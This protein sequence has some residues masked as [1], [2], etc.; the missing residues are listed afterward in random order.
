MFKIIHID[1]DAFFASVEERDD[2]SLKGKPVVVGG[3]PDSRGV[4]ATCNYVARGFGIHSAMPSSQA[5]RLCPKAVFLKPRFDVYRAVSQQIMSI[6]QRFSDC[7]E[8]L[9]LDEAYLD[10]TGSPLCSG[11]ATLIAR[12]IKKA[13]WEEV[14]LTATAG[15]SYNKFF[16]KTASGMNKPDGL[17]VIRPEDGAAFAKTL[18]IGKF[19]G[20]GRATEEKMKRLGI[21]TGADLLGW[22]EAALTLQ[23]GKAGHFYAQLARGEDPRSVKPHR[24]RKSIGMEQTFQH[25]LRD[26]AEMRAILQ[27]QLRQVS[28]KLQRRNLRALTLVLKVKY[29]DFEQV[30]RSHTFPEPPDEKTLLTSLDALL[31]KTEVNSRAVRLLGVSASGLI[32]FSATTSQPPLC[33]L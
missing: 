27:A 4:V 21:R 30:T 8:P 3:A 14:H 26:V 9:S 19:F 5:F 13:I 20:I 23:F 24:E 17:T 7:V 15:V 31:A 25:D 2:P 1:M 32:T 16:A 22:S 28:E 18:P 10:V 6:F 33:L 29:D 11:S 12:E